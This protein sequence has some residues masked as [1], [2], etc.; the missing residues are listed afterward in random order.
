MRRCYASMS[1]EKDRDEMNRVTIVS[2]GCN[3]ALSGIK[4]AGGI[5]EDLQYS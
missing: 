5:W 3:L 4:A 1:E 2:A